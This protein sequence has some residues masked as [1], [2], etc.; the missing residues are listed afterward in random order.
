[1]SRHNILTYEMVSASTLAQ[2][3]LEL[4][5]EELENSKKGMTPIHDVSPN[6]F[7]QTGLEL[8]EHQ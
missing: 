5:E 7:L 8:E 4:A 2:V 1:V 6:I 3:R